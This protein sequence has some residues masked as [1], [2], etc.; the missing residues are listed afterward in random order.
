MSLSDVEKALGN[1]EAIKN[2]E[3]LKLEKAAS[4]EEVARLRREMTEMKAKYEGKIAE[5]EGKLATHEG[6]RIKYNKIR[7]TTKSFEKLISSTVEKEYRAKINSEVE[8]KW[9]VESP[10]MVREAVNLDISGYPWKCSPQAKMVIESAGRNYADTILR[11]KLLWPPWFKGQVDEEVKWRVGKGMDE[12]FSQRV[13]DQASK[14]ITRRVNQEWPKYISEKVSPHFV[15]ML[16]EQLKKLNQTIEVFC[17]R[18]GSGYY[19]DL[20]PDLIAALIRE[21]RVNIRCSNPS[22][23]D[24]L[25]PH[26][27]PLTL[28]YVIYYITGRTM[29]PSS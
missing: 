21:P 20:G 29:K 14:E 25:W 23:R 15:G 18:C 10:R 4:D 3:P 17:D 26:S 5:L 12:A 16:T 24:L 13:N 28:G 7:Y 27:F 1:S 22:C 6:L 9:E 11:D 8:A 19:V 2:Y